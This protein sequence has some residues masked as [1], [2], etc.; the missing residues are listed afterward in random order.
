MIKIKSA[1]SAPSRPTQPVPAAGAASSEFRG[2][3]KPTVT[4][5]GKIGCLPKHVRAELNRRLDDGERGAA[6]L[7]WL[8]GRPEVQTVLKESRFGGVPINGQNLS[9]WRQGGFV[10]WQRQQQELEFVRLLGEESGDINDAA[11]DEPLAERLE[12][13]LAL[14]LAGLLRT[15]ASQPDAAARE[16][17]ILNVSRELSR[18]RRSNQAGQ[19]LKLDLDDREA[20]EEKSHEAALRELVEEDMKEVEHEVLGEIKTIR[21]GYLHARVAK[22]TLAKKGESL[23]KAIS[24]WL[25]GEEEFERQTKEWKA[26]ARSNAWSR[27]IARCRQDSLLRQV[28]D[29][30]PMFGKKLDA[31]VEEYI[32]LPERERHQWLRRQDRETEE[33]SQPAKSD[34][35]ESSQIKANQGE[36]SPAKPERADLK[37]DSSATAGHAGSD[38]AIL[39]TG[40]A[41]THGLRRLVGEAGPPQNPTSSSSSVG[42]LTCGALPPRQCHDGLL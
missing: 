25:D 21:L 8:N 29:A 38:P 23:P 4:S 3:P 14:A 27:T 26:R 42:A 24:D 32:R 33:S 40:A 2:E 20:E 1:V 19:R 11:G 10:R 22:E 16:R 9:N 17:T 12:A 18:L 35:A 39:S 30:M 13:H 34:Q 28:Y 5:N 41:A 6:I 37:P 15:A 31:E 36:S 7:A